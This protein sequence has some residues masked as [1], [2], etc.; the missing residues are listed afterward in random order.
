MS[1]KLLT[2]DV[3]KHFE[4]KGFEVWELANHGAVHT[5]DCV[6]NKKIVMSFRVSRGYILADHLREVVKRYVDGLPPV[7]PYTGRIENCGS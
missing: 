2:I 3:R 7:H 1:K 4:G 5:M 6:K